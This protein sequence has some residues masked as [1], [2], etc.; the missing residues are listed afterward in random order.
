V[1]SW[2]PAERISASFS[3]SILLIRAV[4]KES[5]KRFNVAVI[6]VDFFVNNAGFSQSGEFLSH[7]PR[8]EQAEVEVN[9]QVLV[10]LTHHFAKAMAGRGRATLNATSNAGFSLCLT[11]LPMLRPKLSFSTS[12]G[13]TSQARRKGAHVMATCPGQRRPVSSMAPPLT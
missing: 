4:L 8:Q 3:A 10:A 9:V 5:R 7:D 6:H 1:I 12:A 2:S 11:W 13:H